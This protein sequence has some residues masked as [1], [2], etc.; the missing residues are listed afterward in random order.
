MSIVDSTQLSR[1]CQSIVLVSPDL[2][3][4]GQ[5]GGQI[6]MI[7]FSRTGSLTLKAEQKVVSSIH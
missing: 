4:V 1:D 7:K 2:L 6:A 3:A 5:Q